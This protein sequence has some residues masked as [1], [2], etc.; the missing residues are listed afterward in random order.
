MVADFREKREYEKC[1]IL[2]RDVLSSK[3]TKKKEA[4][5]CSKN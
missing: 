3:N 1:Q 4:A 5:T 2:E